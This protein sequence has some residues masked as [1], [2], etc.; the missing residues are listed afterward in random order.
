DRSVEPGEAI[1]IMTG[2]PVP[3]GADAVVPV[4]DSRIEETPEGRFVRLTPSEPVVAGLNVIRRGTSIRRGQAVLPVGR[5]LRPQELGALAEM[6]RA[7]VSVHRRPRVAILATGDELVPIDV[8]PGPGQIRNS[9]EMML[10]AQV[11][12]AGGEPIS[13][14][15][16]RDDREDLRRHISEGLRYDVLL[17]S[18]GVSAGK[19]DLVP[20][21]LEAAGVRNVFHKVRVRPGKPLW[22]G[23]RADA[24][25]AR[26]Y[27]FGLPG[28]PVSSMVCFELFVRM[29]LRRLMGVTPAE[30]HSIQATLTVEHVV[31]G[32]RPTYHPAR[33][34]WTETGPQV[35]PIVWH[36]SFDLQATKDANAMALFA[37][38]GRTYAAN[39]RIKVVPWD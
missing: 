19:L 18:G 36:G 10:I 26:C 11:R 5:R 31:A 8:T 29:A 39:E 14:G 38:A 23:I 6:G 22:F 30:P 32:N 12:R 17:L 25:A 13:L 27:V 9:N 33:L 1:Q 2:A 3:D 24:P 35:T 16:A 15:V 7:H 21:Q 28:N 20:T 37:E 4:E 34:E